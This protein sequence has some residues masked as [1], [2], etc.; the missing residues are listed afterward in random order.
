M[1]CDISDDSPIQKLS[2][3]GLILGVIPDAEYNCGRA[4]I[5][6]GGKLLLYTDGIT[7]T[8]SPSEEPFGLERLEKFLLKYS[9][10]SGEENIAEINSIVEL[11]RES[12]DQTDD[13]T[14]LIVT[15][16]QNLV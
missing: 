12:G 15:R 14:S 11:F 10:A 2:E 3:G 13:V 16:L 1:L 9:K 7:E 4:I 5:K 8:F 6:E